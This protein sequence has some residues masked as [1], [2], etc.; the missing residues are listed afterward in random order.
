MKIVVAEDDENSR[1][2]LHTVFAASGYQVA[3]FDNGLKALTYLQVESADL[4]VSDILMPEMD[5]YGFCKAVKQNINLQKIPFIFY[6]ATYT[7][8]QDE[9][10]AMTLGASKFLVKPIPM[11]ALLQEV[12]ECLGGEKNNKTPK[13]RGLYRASPT[14]LDKQHADRVRAKLDQKI[15]ELNSEK[16]KLIENEARFRDFAEASADWF[17]ESDAL[18]NIDAVTGGPSGLS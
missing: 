15:G 5:G 6:T 10:F 18:L 4:I 17:W 11:E 16:Q 7:S 14:K 12:A 8:D 3:S 2:L 1:E 13:S 9:R